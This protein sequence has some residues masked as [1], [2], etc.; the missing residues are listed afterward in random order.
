MI[1]MGVFFC[2]TYLLRSALKV[3]WCTIDLLHTFQVNRLN[4][5]LHFVLQRR[6]TCAITSLVKKKWL[7]KNQEASFYEH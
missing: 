2:E 7:L 6:L 5:C 3:K 4:I 1:L